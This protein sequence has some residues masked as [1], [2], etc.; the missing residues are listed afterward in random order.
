VQLASWD[1]RAGRA[2]VIIAALVAF[3]LDGL[4]PPA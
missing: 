3:G 2:V 4:A 1:E